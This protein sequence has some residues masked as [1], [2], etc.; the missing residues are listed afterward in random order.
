MKIYFGK[1]DSELTDMME[2]D[3]WFIHDGQHYEYAFVLEKDGFQ[4]VDVCGRYIPLTYEAVEELLSASV[5][6][7]NY[8]KPLQRVEKTLERI[9]SDEVRS[10]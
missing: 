10:T 7:D 5:I 3:E 9:L 2:D 1:V 8:T 6:L 4:I